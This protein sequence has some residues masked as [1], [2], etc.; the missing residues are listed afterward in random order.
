LEISVADVTVNYPN[1]GTVTVNA[2]VDG[3]YNISVNNVKYEVTV[4]GG[5]GTFNVNEQLNPGTYEIA[6]NVPA[7][8]NYT[9][10]TGDAVYKVLRA[11][12]DFSISGAAEI[13]YGDKNT[14]IPSINSDATGTIE[15]YIGEEK[16]GEG[17]VSQGF[18][19]D[20]LDVGTYT[21]VA[22]YLGDTNYENA[23]AEFVFKVLPTDVSVTVANVEVIYPNTGTVTVTAPVSGT[24]TVTINGKEYEVAVGAGGTGSKEIPDVF[25]VGDYAIGVTADLG[26]NY[27]PVNIP[28][29]AI[30]S[31]SKAQS[32]IA[33]IYDNETKTFNVTLD[34]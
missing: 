15:Y 7:S 28:N 3:K 11:E 22:K 1:K 21:I 26:D 17:T 20:V 8:V 5:V 19:T 31:V 24:Y 2:N 14:I 33:V 9:G 12:P 23:T 32:T 27:N 16:V 34:G 29:A 18:E 13:E 10:A 6:W 4:A 25:G 30:Y